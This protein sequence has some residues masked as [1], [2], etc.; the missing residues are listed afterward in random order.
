MRPFK[1]LRNPV[2]GIME[3][4]PWSEDRARAKLLEIRQRH[5]DR[6]NAEDCDRARAAGIGHLV[7]EKTNMLRT[8]ELIADGDADG[9]EAV[10]MAL[11]GKYQVNQ[12]ASQIKHSGA[13]LNDAFIPE[14]RKFC[15]VPQNDD[16]VEY[17]MP[18]YTPKQKARGVRRAAEPLAA[19]MTSTP[20]SELPKRRPGRPRKQDMAAV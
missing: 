16:G 19:G 12:M 1:E 17:P 4:I 8:I 6:L 3:R 13:E 14:W 18:P 5:K 20:T 9:D 15:S 7:D 10:T 2:T 11:S